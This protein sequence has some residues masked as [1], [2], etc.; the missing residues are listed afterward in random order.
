MA[1]DTKTYRKL[2]AT[3]CDVL[4]QGRNKDTG[5]EWTMYEV[6]AVDEAGSPVEAKLRAFD[7]LPLNELVEYAVTRRDD[8][9]HGTSYTLELPKNRRPAK[10]DTGFKVQIDTLKL[11][12]ANLEQRT[13]WLLGLIH[14]LQ[15]AAGVELSTAPPTSGPQSAAT[16]APG[17]APS[18][19]LGQGPIPV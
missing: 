5:R 1:E 4:R 18:A 3:S 11:Q 10:K 19:A 7:A 17:A 8:P 9:R 2:T 16:A 13:E 15:S 6:Y 12:V 14:E